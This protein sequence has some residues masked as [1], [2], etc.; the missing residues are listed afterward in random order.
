MFDTLA[1][2][3]KTRIRVRRE[4]MPN[5]TLDFEI[6]RLVSGPILECMPQTTVRDAAMQMAAHRCLL[7]SGMRHIGVLREQDTLIG[8]LGLSGPDR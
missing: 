1:F 7:E 3:S 5:H 8:P 2:I 6:G 4:A